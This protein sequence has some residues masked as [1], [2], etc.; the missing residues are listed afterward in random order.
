MWYTDSM[1]Q[2]SMLLCVLVLLL[3]TQPG[4]LIGYDH[5]RVTDHH[6][7]PARINSLRSIRCRSLHLSPSLQA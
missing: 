5:M 7:S 2:H 3:G 4:R 1:I 6:T